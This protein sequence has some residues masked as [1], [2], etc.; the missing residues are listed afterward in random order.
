MNPRPGEVPASRPHTLMS[1]QDHLSAPPSGPLGR[2][3]GLF[4]GRRRTYL[5]DASYQVRSA[6]VA[7]LGMAFL[8]AFAAALF[9]LLSLE[10]ARALALRAPLLAH[11]AES[12]DARSVLYLV[13]AGIIFVGA[14]FF[15]QI[16]ETHKTAGVVYRVTRGLKEIEV[17]RWGATIMLRK[18]DNFKEMEEAFNTA[19]R[20]LRDAVE[21]D[22]RGLQGIE[23]Q[24]RLIGREFESGNREG[25]LVLLRQVAS[26]MQAL[27]ERKRNLLEASPGAHS[28]PKI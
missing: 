19:T 4:G 16:L 22:L 13:V 28:R 1:G 7:V 27:R 24:I 15:I 18:H 23:G 21:E 5:V 14:I 8:L 11:G 10:N 20:A 6:L 26:E 9:H 25:A 17:G 3:F 2:L 12:G